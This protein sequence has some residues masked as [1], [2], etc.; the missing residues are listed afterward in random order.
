MSSMKNKLLIYILGAL[1]FSPFMVSCKIDDTVPLKSNPQLSD[2]SALFINRDIFLSC[3]VDEGTPDERRFSYSEGDGFISDAESYIPAL[4]PYNQQTDTAV[5]YLQAERMLFRD[6][7]RYEETFEI[8][9]V[10]CLPQN[11][12]EELRKD[13]VFNVGDRFWLNIQD[14]LDGVKVSY[15]DENDDYWSTEF[16]SQSID[17]RFIVSAVIE[18]D[19]NDR[20]EY[21]VFGEFECTLRSS[22]RM[23]RLTR[24]RF[25][26]YAGK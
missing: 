6:T 5:S 10:A 19:I 15:R 17:S 24:G 11:S 12:P 25:K 22:N 7:S 16:G 13:I 14:T 23:M 1:M 2:S 26:M 8:E 18:N 20:S 9:L 21:I 3:R 4:C